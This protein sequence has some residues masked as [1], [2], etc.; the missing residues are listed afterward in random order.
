MRLMVLV[1]FA[2]TIGAALLIP[3][4]AQQPPGPVHR[5][6]KSCILCVKKCEICVKGPGKYYS[7]VE[8]CKATCRAR[9]VTW[10]KAS[11]KLNERC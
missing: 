9:G 2:L 7:G 8:D 3:A 11:C 4:N 10:S 1:L 5:K 6:D